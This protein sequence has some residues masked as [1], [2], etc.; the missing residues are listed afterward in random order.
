MNFIKLYPKDNVVLATIDFKEGDEIVVDGEKITLMDDIPNAHKI[1]ICDLKKGEEIIK[2]ENVIGVASQEIKKG[3]WVHMH[4]IQSLIGE[5]RNYN[6][7]FNPESVFPGSSDKTFMGY[8][9]KDGGAGIR[10]YVALVSTVFCANGPQ[11]DIYELAKAKYAPN[12]HFDGFISF[13]QE[14]GCSQTGEELEKQ[15]QTIAGVIRNANFGGVLMV[16]LGCEVMEPNVL[17]KYLGDYDK[18]RIK[19]IT[20]QAV[21]DE[22]A[23][24]MKMIDEIMEEVEQDRRTP[25]N[26]GRLHIGMNCGGSDGYSGITA[27][28]VLGNLCDTLVK[29]GATMNMTEVPEMMGAEHILMNRCAD[30]GVFEKM[31]KM[32]DNYYSYFERYGENV[33]ANATQGNH[34]GGLSTLEDKSLGCIQKSGHCAVMDILNYGERAETNGFQIVCGPGNDLAGITAQVAAGAVLIIFTTGRGTPTGFAAPTFRISSNTALA[35]RKPQWV[36]FDAGK[37]LEAK[38][39]AEYKVLDEELYLNII[40]I[41]NGRKKTCNEKNGYWMLGCLK[42]GVTL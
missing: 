17:E 30:K 26:I 41:V 22:K 14:F 15:A 12:D 19:Y 1:A 24:A 29:E 39:E 9:R 36:D 6:Y 2:Y 4:N 38:T 23:A 21:T 7:T 25:I 8:H 40:D 18:S 32:M 5:E 31:V 34:A 16:S 33:N 28:K 42:D 13:T 37:I 27:N 3:E 10:N 35:Q 11:R 20:T